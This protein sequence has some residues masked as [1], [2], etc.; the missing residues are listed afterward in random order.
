MLLDAILAPCFDRVGCDRAG[1]A[2]AGGTMPRA[3]R[4]RK[5]SPKQKTAPEGAVFDF[6]C[7]AA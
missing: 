4:P 7:A 1:S 2:P 3:G 5:R 6:V